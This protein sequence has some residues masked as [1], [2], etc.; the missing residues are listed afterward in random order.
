MQQS[1]ALYLKK[2]FFNSVVQMQKMLAIPSNFRISLD[3][4]ELATFGTNYG[5]QTSDKAITGCTN[6]ALRYIG[7][8]PAE[9]GLDMIDTLVFFSENFTLQNPS[10]PKVQRIESRRFWWPLCGRY[11][12]RTLIFK[13]F[14]VDAC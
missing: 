4:F 8:F 3:L 2:K 5:L 13:P 6:V 9:S 7:P 11:E 1:K 10:G 14:L 12:A